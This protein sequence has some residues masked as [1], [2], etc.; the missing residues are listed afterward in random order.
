MLSFATECKTEAIEFPCCRIYPAAS[1]MASATTR[2]WTRL[3]A[4]GWGCLRGPADHTQTHRRTDDNSRRG[5]RVHRCVRL[6]NDLLLIGVELVKKSSVVQIERT[7]RFL[8][9]RACLRSVVKAPTG[10]APGYP[11]PH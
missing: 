1:C 2:F 5:G 6:A 4:A 10:G 3:P 11:P 7:S 8:I 9:G